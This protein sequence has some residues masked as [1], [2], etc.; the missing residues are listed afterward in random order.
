MVQGPIGDKQHSRSN[1]RTRRSTIRTRWAFFNTPEI[2]FEGFRVASQ[3]LDEDGGVEEHGRIFLGCTRLWLGDRP[4]LDVRD[5]TSGSAGIG[6]TV[7]CRTRG[8]LTTCEAHQRPLHL[9]VEPVGQ[10]RVVHG[11]SRRFSRPPP[12][13]P[14]SRGLL[15]AGVSRRAPARVREKSASESIVSRRGGRLRPLCD[16]RERGVGEENR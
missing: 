8:L 10:S 2:L 9:V 13:E 16:A 6:S 1:S 11:R 7:V 5:D 3:G 14:S 4:H 12:D 15:R